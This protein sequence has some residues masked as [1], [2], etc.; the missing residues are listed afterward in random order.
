MKSKIFHCLF[1]L[2]NNKVT[3]VI[4]N[5]RKNFEIID[6]RGRTSFDYGDNFWELWCIYT[7][8]VKSDFTDFCF[9]YDAEK[10]VLPEYLQNMECPENDCI[11]NRYIIQY[12]IDILGIDRPVRISNQNGVTVAHGG[13]DTTSEQV[14]KNLT[15]VY[16]NSEKPTLPTNSPPVKI[17]PFIAEMLRKLKNYDKE[18]M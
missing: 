11:W 14:I 10:P 9:I 7:G 6:I 2:E 8:F 17:T 5:D 16:H 15:V 1:W 3:S 18:N 4:M 12:V 13:G